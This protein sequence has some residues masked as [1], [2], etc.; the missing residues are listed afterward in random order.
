MKHKNWWILTF[1]AVSFIWVVASVF[2]V[3]K[4]LCASAGDWL[5]S[6][7]G[8]MVMAGVIAEFILK[9]DFLA[10]NEPIEIRLGQSS[11]IKRKK[12]K[13]VMVIEWVIMIEISVG[14]FLWAYAGY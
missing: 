3:G 13:Q 2:S 12:P 9:Y 6:A 11:T 14:T 1:L 10:V 8:V 7:G 4:P 5:A